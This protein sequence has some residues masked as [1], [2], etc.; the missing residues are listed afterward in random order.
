MTAKYL[1][2]CRSEI[3][4]HHGDSGCR[5]PN[6]ADMHLIGLTVDSTDA[7]V[8]ATAAGWVS[9]NDAISVFTKACD[10]AAEKGFDRVLVDCLSVEGELSTMERYE[11][12]RTVAEYCT[13]R[14]MTPKVAAVGQAP[15]IDGFAARV[16]SNR[17]LVAETFSEL[18]KAMGWLK[19]FG[20][21]AAAHKI[22]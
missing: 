15:L 16:A 3:I 4:A 2:D 14:G 11:L 9:P 12:G 7:I 8:V 20:S 17:G 13:S 1:T 6:G 21:K 19:G 5:I 10:L 18:Q 22:G